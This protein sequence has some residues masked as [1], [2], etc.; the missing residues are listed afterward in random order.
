MEKCA[1]LTDEQLTT[2]GK[3]LAA[4]GHVVRLMSPEYV[5]PYVK[6]Q[7]NECGSSS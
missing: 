4:Q 3:A 7:E 5:G 2:L 6:T 1:H